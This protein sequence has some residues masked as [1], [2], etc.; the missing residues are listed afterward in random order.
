VRD[1][2]RLDVLSALDDK[3]PLVIEITSRVGYL[4]QRS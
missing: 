2:T 4:F 3:H 1:S